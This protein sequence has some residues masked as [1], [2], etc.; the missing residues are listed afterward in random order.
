VNGP[1]TAAELARQSIKD[2]KKND[3]LALAQHLP[4]RGSA[5]CDSTSASTVAQP[6]RFLDLPKELRLMVYD[7]LPNQT[8]RIQ[9]CS[10]QDTNYGTGSLTLLITCV[11]TAILRTCRQIKT[12][13]KDIVRKRA[14]QYLQA[15]CFGSPTPR[16]ETN[17]VALKNLN[18]DWLIEH[19]CNTYVAMLN[20]EYAYEQETDSEATEDYD[21]DDDSDDDKY[22]PPP[23]QQCLVANWSNTLAVKG[24]ELCDGTRE[25]G[26]YHLERF[27]RCA[28]QTLLYQSRMTQ[29]AEMIAE[30]S[31]HE[32]KFSDYPHGPSLEI[33]LRVASDEDLTFVSSQLDCFVTEWSKVGSRTGLST[34]LHLLQLGVDDADKQEAWHWELYK[35]SMDAFVYAHLDERIEFS[36]C[37]RFSTERAF[38]VE[39]KD[40]YDRLWRQGDWF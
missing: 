26:D 23:T 34:I 21:W 27:L 17:A 16:M 9:F 4:L 20:P 19:L 7:L 33:A 40:V 3:F 22:I 12:E 14:N 15:S 25:E 1:R 39:Q 6:F 11:P 31:E 32:T 29:I 10:K 13:A 36:D 37:I 8:E 5:L 18:F 30:P 28:L 38:D 35:K 24:F 2:A